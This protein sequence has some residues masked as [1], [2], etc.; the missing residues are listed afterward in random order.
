LTPHGK[1]DRQAL[2]M[3]ASFVADESVEYVAP[4]NDAEAKLAEI[5]KR[6]LK[7]ERVG[8]HESFFLL[9]GHSL[10]AVQLMEEVEKSFDVA[11]PLP[12]IFQHDTVEKLAAFVEGRRDQTVQ[13][14]LVPLQADGE[15]APLFFVH[16][17]EGTVF[18]YLG[19]AQL[20]GGGRP[21][22]GLQA[23]G[24]EGEALPIRGV[25]A[26]AA[27]YVAAIR[28]V[29]PAGPY[30]LGG[31]SFGGLVAFEMAQQLLA[32]G[33]R[34][35]WLGLV[36]SFVLNGEAAFREGEDRR[37]FAANA[38]EYLAQLNIELRLSDEELVRHEPGEQVEMILSNLADSGVEVP[39][40]VARQ[41]RFLWTMTK[42]NAEAGSRYSPRVYPGRIALFR[43]ADD[44]A[45]ER[46]TAVDPILQW[47]S[48]TELPLAVSRI[49]GS[50]ASMML[51]EE[52]LTVLAD[53][54]RESLEDASRAARET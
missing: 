15:E 40:I 14:P 8:I 45:A 34:V 39:E 53:R 3:P 54:M 42:I 31:W 24:L 12:A 51:N 52:N 41:A 19:L 27:H 7:V 16:P 17:A 13:L 50:H 28:G 38:R 22:Y 9:G 35:A 1:I 21:F 18:A 43:A 10:S 29:Q 33:E 32:A 36:D 37:M 47:Q 4:R 46:E 25:G 2:P 5:W 49:P 26:L 48:L 20:L 6:L 23:P 30:H 44:E 11:I